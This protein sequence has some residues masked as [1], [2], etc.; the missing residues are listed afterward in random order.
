MV[1][2]E[3]GECGSCRAACK[4]GRQP[5]SIT[6][7]T[8][9]LVINE[10]PPD[11]G[12]GVEKQAGHRVLPAKALY[13]GCIIAPDHMRRRIEG[14]DGTA[15]IALAAPGNDSTRRGCGNAASE[16]AVFQGLLPTFHETTS[17]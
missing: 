7:L 16:N 10:P 11:T 5:V 12:A 2:H 13:F 1:V 9:Q 15:A 14:S 17:Q 4:R 8:K 3:I 6:L